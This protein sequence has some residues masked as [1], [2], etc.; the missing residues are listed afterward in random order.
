MEKE[1]KGLCVS[2]YVCR[3]IQEKME[4]EYDLHVY[5]KAKRQYEADPVTYTAKELGL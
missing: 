3:L 4:D 1:E 5:D 2:E